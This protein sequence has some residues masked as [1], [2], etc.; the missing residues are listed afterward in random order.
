M[1]LTGYETYCVYL[2]LKNHFTKD[3][4][5]FFKYNGKV[6]VS[7]DAFLTRRDR[8]Q[9][10]KFARRHDDP[11]EFMLANFLEGKTWIGEFLD[12]EASDIYQRYMKTIQSMS[13]VFKNEIGQVEDIRELFKSKPNEYPLIVQ[14][15][16]NRTISLQSFVILDNFVQFIPKFD[17]RMADDF[18]WNK[19][20][21]LARKYKPFLIQNLDQK[22][23]KD[24]LKQQTKVTI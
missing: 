24:I 21:V 11:K 7:K 10:E 14:M 15:L 20:S 4:Y 22:K 13:Y 5:D 9:F 16:M 6:H 18:L 8:F 2:A 19:Y 3:S 17:E 23:F 1:K 12:D